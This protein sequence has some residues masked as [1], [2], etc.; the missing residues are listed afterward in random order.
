MCSLYRE[1]GAFQV[2]PKP[3]TL[4]SPGGEAQHYRRMLSSHSACGNLL[5]K[6]KKQQMQAN[7]SVGNNFSAIVSAIRTCTQPRSPLHSTETTKKLFFSSIF[8]VIY[9][10]ISRLPEPRPARECQVRQSVAVPFAPLRDHF[11]VSTEASTTTSDAQITVCRV[12]DVGHLPSTSMEAMCCHRHPRLLRTAF[13]HRCCS[14]R[15]V[16]I[17]ALTSE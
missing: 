10:A 7:T 6:W 14:P 5:W 4:L 15:S 13:S 1:S 2:L 8:T 16:F 17:R 9:L 3:E 11:P 12:Q